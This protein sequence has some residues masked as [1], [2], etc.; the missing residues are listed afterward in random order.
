MGMTRVGGRGP[1]LLLIFLLVTASLEQ[2]VELERPF[3][4]Q[5][6]EFENTHIV[7][8]LFT[9][10]AFFVGLG[11]GLIRLALLRV[12]SLPAFTE[13]FADLTCHA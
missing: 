2:Y 5:D 6:C 1:D 9:L 4:R 12:E 11:F 13:D 8:G 7:A 10:V 3:G